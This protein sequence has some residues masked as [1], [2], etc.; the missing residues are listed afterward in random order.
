MAKYTSNNVYIRRKHPQG[1][2]GMLGGLPGGPGGR[3]AGWI[4]IYQR[5]LWISLYKKKHAYID[6]KETFPE[7]FVMRV[8]A[9]QISRG[10][11]FAIRVAL[12]SQ[13]SH[14]FIRKTYCNLI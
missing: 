9:A 12:K 5:F 14:H 1:P 3:W 13:V 4:T 6:A 8:S 10:N 7:G 2:P 11:L